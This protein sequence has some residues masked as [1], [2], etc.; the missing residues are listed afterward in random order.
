M[1]NF[2]V[3]LYGERIEKN[4]IQRRR[5]GG[6]ECSQMSRVQRP[7][8]YG[9]SEVGM[10]RRT[11]SGCQETSGKRSLIYGQQPC[12]TRSGPPLC[13]SSPCPFA[14]K[15]EM[16]QVLIKCRPLQIFFIFYNSSVGVWMEKLLEIFR[17]YWNE[18]C[19]FNRID[20]FKNIFDESFSQTSVLGLTL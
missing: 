4:V 13:H 6:N 7:L 12:S 9:L 16:G 2:P 1:K 3:I 14:I 15:I 19:F 18:F 11:G 20:Q 5:F 17:K 10:R 8:M